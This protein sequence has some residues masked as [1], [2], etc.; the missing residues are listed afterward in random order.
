MLNAKVNRKFTELVYPGLS[1][2]I[3]GILFQTRMELSGYC[4]E[5]QYCDMI[6]VKLKKQQIKYEREKILP[7]QFEGEQSGRNKIDFLI[8]DKI[9]LEV[10]TK[11]GLDRD[12]Y[13]QVK[14]Y[15]LALS[16]KLGIVVNFHQKFIK[17]KR[18][19]NSAAKE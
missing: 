16:K 7:P 2:K 4:N 8:E 3:N 1:Y 17:P 13:Y 10:K 18:I 12:D 14:R 19:L 6:E 5:K 15:L 9:I 11:R